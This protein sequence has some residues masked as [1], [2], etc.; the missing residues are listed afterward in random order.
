MDESD[1]LDR[2]IPEKADGPIDEKVLASIGLEFSVERG[3]HGQ[4][5]AIAWRRTNDGTGEASGDSI[6]S[7]QNMAATAVRLRSKRS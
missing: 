5:Q 2:R 1:Q 4:W 7:L 6:A 3:R